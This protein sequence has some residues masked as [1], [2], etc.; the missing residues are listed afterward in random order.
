MNIN[1]F[2]SLLGGDGLHITL[3]FVDSIQE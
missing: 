2:G 3:T 1:V